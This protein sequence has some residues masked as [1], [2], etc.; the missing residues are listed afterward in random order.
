MVPI[1]PEREGACQVPLSTGCS[2]LSFRSQILILKTLKVHFLWA[3]RHD[4]TPLTDSWHSLATPSS[5][6]QLLQSGSWSWLTS[7]PDPQW[8]QDCKL[9]LVK[10]T[11]G[12]QMNFRS[13]SIKCSPI[14]CGCYD[15]N[16]CTFITSL[17]RPFPWHLLPQHQMLGR[18]GLQ[19]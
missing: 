7:N 6:R 13:L 1:M 8:P 18:A 16:N 5:W 19:W 10:H 11:R 9:G 17:A 12:D 15:F 14:R 2:F 3:P 4:D